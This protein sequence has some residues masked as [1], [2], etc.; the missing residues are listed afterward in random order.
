M[1]IPSRPTRPAPALLLAIAFALFVWAPTARA[2]NAPDYEPPPDYE[3]APTPQPQPEPQPEPEP[4]PPA[5]PPGRLP[6]DFF[7][8]VSEDLIYM[9][10]RD[11]K[12]TLRLQRLAGIRV[13]RQTLRWSEV[14]RSPGRF[15]FSAFDALVA[16]AA[17]QGIAVLPILMDTPSFRLPS[18]ASG[19]GFHPPR[20]TSH[21][22]RFAI[23]AVKRYGPAGTLWSDNPRLA[24]RPIR[25]WQIWN[26][27]NLKPYWPQGPN[28][29]A[30]TRLLRAAYMSIKRRDRRAEIV[31]GGLPN[32]RSGVPLVTYTKAM[33]RAGAKRYFDTFAV[34]P[35]GRTSRDA[36]A[37][38][39]AVRRVMDRSRDRRAKLWVTEFGWSDVGP[40]S[41]FRAGRVGQATQIRAALIRLARSRKSLRLR[42]AILYNWRDG[43]PYA[44]FDFWGLHTG[45][46]RVSGGRKPAYFAFKRTLRQLR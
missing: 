41:A 9:S 14:E 17:R 36:H 28:A 18:R 44:G 22:A 46:V 1:P 42:G 23:A 40:P 39:V 24:R 11:R 16:D 2:Q 33:Y 30:Y 15:D 4:V 10:D 12:A 34:H 45:L 3:P 29:R 31:A 20:R 35:Y 19:R 7:G 25:A 37:L 21:F 26:E 13:L 5:D 32:S 27:P 8:I 38:V 6:A 43:L